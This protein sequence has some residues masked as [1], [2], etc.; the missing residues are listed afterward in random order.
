MEHSV[1]DEKHNISVYEN[2]IEERV[3]ENDTSFISDENINIIDISNAKNELSSSLEDSGNFLKNF[4]LGKDVILN[5]KWDFT[6]NIQGKIVHVNEEEVFVDCLLDID[7]KI[8]EHRT[9]P[10]Q[11]FTNLVEIVVNKTVLIKTKVKPGTIKIDVFPGDGIVKLEFF[12]QKNKWDI[13]NGSELDN[14]LIKW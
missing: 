9:F 4:F 6:A 11:L 10:I 8:F 12:N 13:L 14:K 1:V 7:K 2:F 3:D 5:E